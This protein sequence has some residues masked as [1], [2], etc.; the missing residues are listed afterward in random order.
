M[1]TAAARY[2]I[3]PPLLPLLQQ[4]HQR[5]QDWHS[6]LRQGRRSSRSIGGNS[7]G[8]SDNIFDEEGKKYKLAITLLLIWYSTAVLTIK[9]VFGI[10]K[11]HWQYT[12]MYWQ[13]TNMYWQKTKVYL[14]VDPVC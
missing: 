2:A 3:L 1:C 5:R 4:R 10:L 14:S 11:V 13:N 12:H 9:W 8:G 7:R 6:R